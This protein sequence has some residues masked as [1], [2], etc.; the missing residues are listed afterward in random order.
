VAWS[1]VFDIYGARIDAA[2]GVVADPDAFVI[3]DA[4]GNQQLPAVSCAGSS[5][6]AAWADHRSGT[7]WQPYGAH[8]D[9]TSGAV[10]EPSGVA[11]GMGVLPSLSTNTPPALAVACD[12]DRCLVV[13]EDI[14][15]GSSDVYA[16]VAGV[17]DSEVAVAADGAINERTPDVAVAAVG[18]FVVGY[19]RPVAGTE[20]VATR[21]VATPD[22]PAMDDAGVPDGEVTG[23]AGLDAQDAATNGL[24]AAGGCAC[25]GGGGSA[26]APFGALALALVVLCAGRVRTYRRARPRLRREA[27]RGRRASPVTTPSGDRTRC[28]RGSC[29][30]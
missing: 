22:P 8:I 30:A 2:T 17:D 14:R 18:R 4:T 20:R 25:D 19:T 12:G 24:V 26:G 6:L 21:V 15:G 11:I 16:A 1:D 3:S 7:M 28:A 23:D 9:L 5:C 10:A 27:E 13:W 29:T